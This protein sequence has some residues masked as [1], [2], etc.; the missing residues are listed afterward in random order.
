MTML[1]KL[2][3]PLGNLFSFLKGI[4][5]PPEEKDSIKPILLGARPPALPCEESSDDFEL[6]VSETQELDGVA[7]I[8][9]VVSEHKKTPFGFTVYRSRKSELALVIIYQGLIVGP[10]LTNHFELLASYALKKYELQPDST[11]FI[12]AYGLNDDHINL[13]DIALVTMHANLN[14]STQVLVDND[15]PL[16][17][18]I[19]YKRPRWT[20]LERLFSQ[21]KAILDLSVE[22]RDRMDRPLRLAQ[23]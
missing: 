13:M 18:D 23:L 5:E 16:A 12:Q 10:S 7:Y 9:P 8:P 19:L 17:V 1:E 11:M 4:H 6:V 20:N 3:E 15:G 2:R 22:V 14:P 21:L